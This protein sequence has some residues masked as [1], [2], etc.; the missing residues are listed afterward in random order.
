MN[1]EKLTEKYKGLKAPQN[2]REKIMADIPES[3]AATENPALIKRVSL[4][5]ITAVV[6]AAAIMLSLVIAVTAVA[7]SG[8]NIFMFLSAKPTLFNS[9]D[10]IYMPEVVELSDNMAIESVIVYEENG[11]NIF[12]M[13]ISHTGSI[14]GNFHGFK[15]PEEN[16]KNIEIMFNDGTSIMLDGLVSIGGG[17]GDGVTYDY[18]YQCVYEYENFPNETKFT[19]KNNALGLSADIHLSKSSNELSVTDNGIKRVNLFSADGSALLSYNVEMLRP[20]L[21]ESD[22]RFYDSIG[23]TIQGDIT[24]KN[25]N[26]TTIGSYL[27]TFGSFKDFIDYTD[28]PRYKF[29]EARIMN[30]EREKFD[31]ITINQINV[32]LST[33]IIEDTGMPEPKDK[34]KV[35]TM[36]E[37]IYT[38]PLPEL[39]GRIEFE[40]PY[41]LD[42]IGEFEIYFEAIEYKGGKLFIEVAEDGIKYNGFEDVSRISLGF[43]GVNDSNRSASGIDD[44]FYRYEMSIGYPGGDTVDIALNQLS[45]TINGLWK[46]N[47]D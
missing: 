33:D 27:S 45:Y 18:F 1:S 5:K 28:Y 19:V 13:V 23:Y 20:T 8:Q 2:L 3:P 17:G 35:T 40:T 25:G 42:T 26:A 15:L 24:Y 46:I 31:K 37:F 7:L 36:P 41:Y 39:G 4:K 22:N 30:A 29:G 9:G 47:F 11:E 6:C 38:V 34:L 14:K 32:T 12:S 21:L 43:H 16:Y 44:Y 10:I